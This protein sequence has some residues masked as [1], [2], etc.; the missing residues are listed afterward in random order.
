MAKRNFDNFLEA[1]EEYANDDFCPKAFHKWVGLS[2]LA[3]ALERKVWLKQ[4]TVYH[5]P[6]IYVLL[7]SHPG[8][9]KSTALERGVDLLEEVRVKFNPEIKM[10]PTRITD[11]AFIEMMDIRAQLSISPTQVVYHSSGYF[12]ASEASASALQNLFGDFN[13]TITAM[14]DCPKIFRSKIKAVKEVAELQNCCMNLLAGST[15][16]YLK[17]L[18]NATSVMGGLASRFIYVVNKERLVKEAKWDHKDEI[19]FKTQSKLVEDLSAI[20]RM[21]GRFVPTAGWIDAWEKWTPMFKQE[22]NDLNSPRMESILTRKGTN[23]VKVSMLLSAAENDSMILTEKHWHDA[24][25]LIDSVTKDNAFIV[26]SAIMAD[27]SSQAG[28]TQFI[29]EELESNGR[30]MTV[31]DLKAKLLR[32]GSDLYRLKDT[33]S[34]L[35]EADHVSI[36]GE[37]PLQWVE[38]N[39][40]AKSNI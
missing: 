26:S 9:G 28:I 1:Y 20:N 12:Y 36:K 25:E 19:D 24:Q 15:F 33:L 38:L 5:Y 40:E 31:A 11:A 3:G 32:H 2:V 7:V 35:I 16:D 6:N 29:L 4:A 17:N 14:Y 10:I 30:S 13:A 8:V 23:L 34:N 22:L 27:K 21:Q 18:V 39:V 37:H